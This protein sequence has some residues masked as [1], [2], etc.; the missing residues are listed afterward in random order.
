[1]KDKHDFEPRCIPTIEA[2]QEQYENQLRK[3]ASQLLEDE[4]NKVTDGQES[5][6]KAFR[7]FEEKSESSVT[8]ENTDIEYF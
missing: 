2:M 5:F 6:F 8:D 4:H 7:R 1:M 3:E